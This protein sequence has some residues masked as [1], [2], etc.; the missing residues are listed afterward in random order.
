MESK[1]SVFAAHSDA[2]CLLQFPGWLHWKRQNPRVYLPGLSVM[3]ESY[4]SGLNQPF[5]TH[6]LR[7]LVQINYQCFPLQR[8]IINANSANLSEFSRVVNELIYMKHN[9]VSHIT[10]WS[11]N[12]SC[13][14]FLLMSTGGIKFVS[15]LMTQRL[16]RVMCQLRRQIRNVMI[17]ATQNVIRL[18]LL[19]HADKLE[20]ERMTRGK[21]SV[22]KPRDC[23]STSDL[24]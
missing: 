7:V 17:R 10:W 8:G 1:T 5:V 18:N 23:P 13:F 6:E 2:K 4:T 12:M 20:I 14:L 9:S 3:L 19:P 21:D 15:E 11:Q 22:T 24:L 16:G